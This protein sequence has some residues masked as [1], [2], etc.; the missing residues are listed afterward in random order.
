M[1]NRLQQ[2]VLA[3]NR[4]G[5]G[6][7]PGELVDIAHD[8]KGWVLAQLEAAP[9]DASSLRGLPG[10]SDYLARFSRFRLDHRRARERIARGEPDT[11]AALPTLVERFGADKQAE[12]GQRARQQCLTQTPV[13]ERLTMFWSNHFTVSGDGGSVQLLPGAFEREAIRP[14]IGDDFATLLLAAE[15]HPAMLLYLDNAKSIGPDSRLGQRRNA[16]QRRATAKPAG[17]NENLAREIM[18][19]HT[20]SVDGDYR[21]HDVIELAQGLTGWRTRLEVPDAPSAKGMP[22]L[23]PY[24]SVFQQIA[25]QPGPRTLLDTRFGEPGAEQGR[26]MLRFLARQDDTSTFIARKLVRHFVADTPSGELVAQLARTF[27]QTNGQL[28]AVYRA[29][30]SHDAAWQDSTR[31]FRRPEE[32]LIALYR[33]LA[34][35]PAQGETAWGQQLRLLGQPPFRP[36]G[37]DGWGDTSADWIGADALWKRL[38]IAQRHTDRLPTTRDPMELAQDSLGPWLGADTAV[39]VSLAPRSQAIAIVFASPEFQWR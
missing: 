2:A 37:P 10:T 17:L 33:A 27:R 24:G 34:I 39:A 31:K 9:D 13:V 18:E 16:R 29:L 25:H 6:A 3:A 30:F 15:Q 11:G 26:A 38:L 22:T 14:H 19:L 20:L 5:L 7:R 36:G 4:F 28:S 12:I 35:A 23:T 21:Q 32:F 1:E 8:P